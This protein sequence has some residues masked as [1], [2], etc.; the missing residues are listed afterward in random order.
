MNLLE[1]AIIGTIAGGFAGWLIAYI[2]NKY[3]NRR[4]WRIYTDNFDLP[5]KV[6]TQG[7]VADVED[8]VHVHC[9]NFALDEKAILDIRIALDSFE[10]RKQIKERK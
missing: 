5:L 1:S 6:Y 7:S 8:S 10:F 3:K 9:I 4:S 2:E